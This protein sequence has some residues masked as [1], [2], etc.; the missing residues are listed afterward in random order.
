M[1]AREAGK[2]VAVVRHLRETELPLRKPPRL[3]GHVLPTGQGPGATS[4]SL[5]VALSNDGR[6]RHL[7]RTFI[8]EMLL[9]SAKGD[10]SRDARLRPGVGLKEKG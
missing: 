3:G 4:S 5:D 6:L 1:G 10:D 9:A 8:G 7:L 2:D